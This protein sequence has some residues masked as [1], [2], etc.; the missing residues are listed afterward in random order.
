MKCRVAAFILSVGLVSFYQAQT[1]TGKISDAQAN[2][3]AYA[4]VILKKDK[5][6]R[7]SITDENGNFRIDAPEKG[8]YQLDVLVDGN[9]VHRQELN[10]YGNINEKIIVKKKQNI[11]FKRLNLQQEKR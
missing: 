1:I 10:I 4:E 7:S 9:I 8:I 11:L 5:I 3:K 6:I 2:I